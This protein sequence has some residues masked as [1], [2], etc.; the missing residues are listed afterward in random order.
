VV[1]RGMCHFITPEMARAKG[2]K[3]PTPGFPT[4]MSYGEVQAWPLVML[5]PKCN[6]I[7]EFVVQTNQ[8]N[9]K[10]TQNSN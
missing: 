10:F 2:V 9:V 1:N 6:E 4:R 3:Q 7:Y 5:E 8:G